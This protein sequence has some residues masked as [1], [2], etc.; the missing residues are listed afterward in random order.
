MPWWGAILLVV[1]ITLVGVI[2]L[3]LFRVAARLGELEAG[4][5]QPDQALLLT[6]V[7]DRFASAMRASGVP[8][9]A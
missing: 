3:A 2:A 5:A 6:A 8:L 9:R 1:L 7:A 4:R